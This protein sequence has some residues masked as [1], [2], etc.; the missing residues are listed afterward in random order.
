MKQHIEMIMAKCFIVST[1]IVV[2]AS[3]LIIEENVEG[4][5]QEVVYLNQDHQM[6]Y[7]GKTQT[8]QMAV[9][10]LA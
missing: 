4:P 9:S 7:Q 5:G 1:R 8:I 6:V 3:F 2:D 10:L